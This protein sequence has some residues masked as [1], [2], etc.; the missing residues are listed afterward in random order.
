M[1]SV[2]IGRLKRAG[3]GNALYVGLAVAAVGGVLVAAAA[4]LRAG[5]GVPAAHALAA[6][7]LLA[8]ARRAMGRV[9]LR[10]RLL[11]VSLVSGGLHHL[12]VEQTPSSPARSAGVLH[13]V[14]GL[15]APAGIAMC[16]ALGIAGLVL[17]ATD[18]GTPLVW[19][20]RLLDAW[21]IAG[22][23][24]ALDWALLLHRADQGSHMWSLNRPVSGRDSI[25]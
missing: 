25:P 20:R 3:A 8:R 7:S 23:L 1:T 13:S 24:L 5:A 6:L 19:L 15:L 14:A 11:A 18:S 21:L 12:V 10:L 17:A 9:R 16:L 22:S 2:R 4:L